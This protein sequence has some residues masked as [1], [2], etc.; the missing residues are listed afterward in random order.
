MLRSGRDHNLSQKFK[1][2]P[3]LDQ[4]WITSSARNCQAKS[5]QIAIRLKIILISK[6]YTW[7][8]KRKMKLMNNT[9]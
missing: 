3:K 7:Q 4:A 2:L 1:F 6:K 5:L 9:M 8:K